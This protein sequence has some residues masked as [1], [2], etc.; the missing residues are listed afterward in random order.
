MAAKGL[1]LA[2][3]FVL[4]RILDPHDFGLVALAM[5]VL[6]I[7]EAVSDLPLTQSLIV[8]KTITPDM[9]NTAVTIAGIRGIAIAAVLAVLSV[10]L[11]HFY[12]DDRLSPLLIALSLAP[13]CRGLLS[14]ALVL[15]IK[16]FN[17]R[18]EFLLD[19][20]GKAAT[21][22][23][24][25][26]LA[27]LTGSYWSIAVGT[28]AGPFV[29]LLMSYVFAPVA[30]RPTLK[31]W[32]LFRSSVGWNTASQIVAALNWQ[33][34]RLILA[35]FIPLSNYG[36]FSVA[37]DLAAVAHIAI[38]LPLTRPL[39]SA[40]ATADTDEAFARSYNQACVALTVIG[41]AILS[42][43]S[44]LAPQIVDIA[45]GNAWDGVEDYL[46]L[47]CLTAM[48]TLPISGMQSAAIIAGKPQLYTYRVA[49]EFV[50]KV[51]VSIALIPVYGIYGAIVTR[52]IAAVTALA[53]F[54]IASSTHLKLPART[55]VLSLMRPYLA[56]LACF[57]L[58]SWVGGLFEI[59]TAFDAALSIVAACIAAL[60]VYAV[61]LLTL[62]NAAGRPDGIEKFALRVLTGFLPGKGPKQ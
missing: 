41:C 15:Y 44:A 50:V 19:V 9:L 51:P 18:Y 11:A 14:P 46:F 3:L 27:L 55:L 43:M 25:V 1:D 47:L 34:D 30:I 6:L 17:F 32:H 24:A 62:W 7:V 56:S 35:R 61:V 26:G 4:S 60:P 49:A 37:S 53:Y 54:I 58:A 20:I 5:T 57:V 38:I 28:I 22:L 33:I 2:A 23:T 31:D 12:A 59:E 48:I 21:F 40:L 13:I 10:P 42:L 45:L 8:H 29:I 16:E 36:R 39:M 52:A